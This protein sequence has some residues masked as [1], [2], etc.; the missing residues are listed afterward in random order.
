MQNSAYGREHTAAFD[1]GLLISPIEAGAFGSGRVPPQRTPTGRTP[2]GRAPT[3]R[4]S[5]GWAALNG[6]KAMLDGIGGLG[7]SVIG[8]VIG[9]VFWH[10]VGFWGFVSEVVLAGGPPAPAMAAA[11]YAPVVPEMRS[12]WVQVADATPCTLL[13]L[14]R[15]TGVT[16][17]APCGEDAQALRADTFQGREDRL[18][19]PMVSGW[20]SGASD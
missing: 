2:T 10:F 7:W 15:Q 17:A 14:D 9:A 20:A 3:G 6:A 11:I 5:T 18:V 8:F 19:T 4:T 16:S 13:T 1:E 12:R